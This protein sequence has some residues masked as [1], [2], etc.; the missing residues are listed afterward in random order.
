MVLT[1]EAIGPGMFK[2]TITDTGIGTDAPSQVSGETRDIHALIGLESLVQLDARG[3][4]TDATGLED[5][6]AVTENGGA[7]VLQQSFQRHFLYLPEDKMESGVEWTRKYSFAQ[8]QTDFELN[9]DHVDSY[10]CM[11]QTHFNGAPAYRIQV[12]STMSLDGGS[13][14][15]ARAVSLTGQGTGTLFVAA[16]R[17]MLLNMESIVILRGHSWAGE[18]EI[19]VHMHITTSIRQKP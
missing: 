16:G 11:E 1:V 19:P 7:Q 12:N 8:V 5:N 2:L 14:R 3:L 6:A 15:G 9:F 4:I 13:N 10:R 18:Q 17:C